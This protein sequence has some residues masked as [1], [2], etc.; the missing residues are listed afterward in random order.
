MTH[1]TTMLS[2]TFTVLALY[3]QWEH[4]E[5][6][7][8]IWYVQTTIVFLQ[9]FC[10]LTIFILFVCYTDMISEW[11]NYC[12][13]LRSISQG[14]PQTASTSRYQTILTQLELISPIYN[15]SFTQIL[16]Y[17]LWGRPT[18]GRYTSELQCFKH[19][20]LYNITVHLL[21]FSP[22]LILSISISVFLLTLLIP[23]LLFLDFSTFRPNFVR[24][25]S[26]ISY[27]LYL[28][29]E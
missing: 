12:I 14:I 4:T 11:L 2:C 13:Y 7:P 16:M 25:F 1:T 26:H 5:A 9:T 20:K 21:V 22:I 23:S 6:A 28:I 29:S 15:L 17:T 8:Q 10:K 24:I 18:K 19:K 27:I 3:R